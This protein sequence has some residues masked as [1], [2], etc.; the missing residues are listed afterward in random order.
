MTHLMYVDN[1]KTS[2]TK[3][4]E[5]STPVTIIECPPLKIYAVKSYKNVDGNLTAKKQ[6]NFTADKE[7]ARAASMP[8]KHETPQ[9]KLNEEEFDELRLLVY[10]QPK[11]TGIGKKKPEIFEIPLGGSKADQLKYVQSLPKEI[12]LSDVFKEGAIIDIHSITKGKGFQGPV[13]RFGV[14]LRQKKSEKTKRGPASLGAWKSQGHIMYRVAHAG[15][16]G[17]HTRTEYNKWMIKLSNDASNIN[18]KGGH[19]KYGN[20]KNTYCLITGS[21]GGSKKRLVKMTPP[22]RNKSEML[23]IPKITYISG[24]SQ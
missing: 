2:L 16:M 21:V 13:K 20:V 12:R 10:T 22:I 24:V 7:F 3:G 8:K 15:Q 18:R 23:E 9:I 6:F 4:Q 19:L 17:Y 1:S 11:L 14:R 5:I